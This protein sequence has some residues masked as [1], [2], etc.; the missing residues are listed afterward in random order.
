MFNG[1]ITSRAIKTVYYM[2]LSLRHISTLSE[3]AEIDLESHHVL[4]QTPDGR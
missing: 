2:C 1:I 3:E 4:A